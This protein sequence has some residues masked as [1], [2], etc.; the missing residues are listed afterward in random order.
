MYVFGPNDDVFYG[1]IDKITNNDLI[2]IIDNILGGFIGIYRGF[3]SRGTLVLIQNPSPS[4]LPAPYSLAATM[5]Q[6]VI[7]RGL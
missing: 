4:L 2:L 3:S 6:P 7:K 5:K 1:V